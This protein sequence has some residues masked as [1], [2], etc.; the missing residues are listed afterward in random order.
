MSRREDIRLVKNRRVMRRIFERLVRQ[1]YPLGTR[2]ER[3]TFEEVGTFRFKQALHWVLK[4]RT[5]SGDTVRIAIRGNVPSKDTRQEIHVADRVQRALAHHGFAIGELR[6]P[7]SFGVV[8]RLRL[9]LYENYPGQTLKSLV[10]GR[11]KRAPAVA[12]RAGAWLSA[13]HAKRLRVSP[14]M[15]RSR[16]AAE[17]GYFR[18]DVSRHAPRS[19]GTMIRLL[20]AAVQAQTEILRSRRSS[21][22]TIHGD[23]NL[24]NIVSGSDGSI[25]FIDF[26]NSWTHDPLNDLGNFLAQL[27]ALVWT[28]RCTPGLADRVATAFLRSYQRGRTSPDAQRRIDVHHAWWT[29]QILAYTL[30]TKPKTG[31]RLIARSFATASRLLQKHHYIVHST[32]EQSSRADFRRMLINQTSMLAY[33]ADHLPAFFPKAEKVEAIALTVQPALSATSFLTKYRLAVRLPN[34]ALTE[35]IIRGNSIDSKTYAIMRTLYRARRR[36]FEVIRPL[37]F[38]PRIPYVFY[39]ELLGTP[40]RQAH[41]R[42]PSYQYRLR[43][44]AHALAR[45]HQVQSRGLRR[46]QWQDELNFLRGISRQTRIHDRGDIGPLREVLRTLRNHEHLIWSVRSVL[47]HN[48]FQASNILTT[49]HGIGIIDYTRS[50]FG[51]PGLDVANFRSHLYIMLDGLLLP[52]RIERMVAI[53]TLA[54]RRSIPG[55]WWPGIA[56]SIPI[57][58][59]RSTLDILATTVTNLGPRDPNRRRYVTLLRQRIGYLSRLLQI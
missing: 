11:D 54:Y 31:R 4:L 58:E 44:V 51:H 5:A 35:K 36:G 41:V 43:D 55:S 15:T 20:A 45:F 50:G 26:G 24:G 52:R 7:V 8:P 29:L 22:R 53:F 2:L 23:L 25:G 40:L 9:N 18:D 10:R 28:Q 49:P 38:H 48:D 13:F 57:F 3:F 56:A 33:F 12:A 27:D 32:L 30:S 37:A 14:L 16:I 1:K 21:F 46:L 19:A 34:G 17:A 47:T 42:A 39:E 59:L 6:A